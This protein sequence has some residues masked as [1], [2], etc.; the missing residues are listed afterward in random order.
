[1]TRHRPGFS[2]LKSWIK[3]S[4]S[5]TLATP[6]VSEGATLN[7]AAIPISNSLTSPGPSADGQSQNHN[8][9]SDDQDEG[10]TPILCE[11]PDAASI[12]PGPTPVAGDEQQERALDTV[13]AEQ[14]ASTHSLV[15]VNASESLWDRAYKLLDAEMVA[16]YDLLVDEIVTEEST[17][18]V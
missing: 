15:Q 3:G 8:H 13:G 12:K 17:S 18:C 5:S 4:S 11:G 9:Q 1:M 7:T 10:E 14:S 6:S 2:K 16:E